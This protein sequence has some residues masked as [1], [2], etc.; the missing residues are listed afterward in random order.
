MN[1]E[2]AQNLRGRLSLFLAV[3]T[4]ISPLSFGFRANVNAAP[5]NPFQGQTDFLRRISLTTNDLVFSSNTG[6]L[7]ASVPSSVGSGG[8][9]ITTINPATGAIDAATFVGSEPN[10]LALADDGQNLYVSLDGPLAVRRFNVA[11]N[12]AGLQFT[13]GQDPFSGRFSVRDFAVAPGN[14][15]VLAIA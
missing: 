1:Y 2:S 9:N 5:P 6:K 3:T 15:D 13:L 11:T 8:N 7:Y 10:R 14:P 12:T 4:L